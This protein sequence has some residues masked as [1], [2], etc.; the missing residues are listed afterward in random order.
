LRSSFDFGRNN[1]ENWTAGL[2]AEIPLGN[3]AARSRVRR[4][5]LERVQRLATR[6]LRR[7]AIQQEVF[8][9]VDPLD[10]NRERILAARNEVVLA[11]RTY[12][13]ERRQF[14]LGRRTSTDV[15]D[16]ADRL[17]QAQSREVQALGEYEIAQVDI[18]FATGALLGHGRVILPPAR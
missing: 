9:A 14:E 18:A 10:Q 2:T 6:D 17:A 1:A 16:A 7:M 8:D 15:L 11:G 4:A 13:A 5:I 12:E 3:A